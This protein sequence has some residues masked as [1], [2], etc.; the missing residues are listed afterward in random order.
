MR[1]LG[2]G[3]GNVVR[4]LEAKCAAISRSQAV[5]E[6]TLEGIILTANENFLSAMGY[7]LDE[8]VGKHHSMFCEES[9]VASQDYKA[10]WAD[11][12]SGTYQSAAYRRLAKGGREVWIQASYNP[13]LDKSGKPVK[14]IKFATM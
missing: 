13:V 4:D 14:V 11:L 12:R 2:F 10:F 9:Y 3:Q 7:K 8:I 6:F 5:I 1:A